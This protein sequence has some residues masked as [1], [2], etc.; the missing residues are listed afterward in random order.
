MLLD[1]VVK[2]RP[3]QLLAVRRVLPLIINDLIFDSDCVFEG[4]DPP[5]RCLSSLEI[6]VIDAAVYKHE[7]PILPFQSSC[8]LLV[9]VPFFYGLLEVELRLWAH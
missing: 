7:F 3:Q 4:L 5:L 8:F 2:V 1:L 9:F 6:V